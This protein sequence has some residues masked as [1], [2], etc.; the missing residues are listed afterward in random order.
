M[1]LGLRF[2]QWAAGEVRV[3]PD[4]SGTTVVMGFPV[5]G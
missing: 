5:S 2:I 3:E 1:G 4:A